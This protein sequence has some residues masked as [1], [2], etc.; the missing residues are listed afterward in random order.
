[1]DLGLMQNLSILDPARKR[2]LK[3]DLPLLRTIW[4]WNGKARKC[5]SKEIIGLDLARWEKARVYTIDCNLFFI[6]ESFR[7]LFAS[8]FLELLYRQLAQCY[9]YKIS[10]QHIL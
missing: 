3:N 4:F 7:L 2:L 1:M 6:K 5:S 8:I 10:F 9:Y